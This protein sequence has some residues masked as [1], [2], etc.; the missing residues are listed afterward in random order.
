MVDLLH[1][2]VSGN[3]RT[4]RILIEYDGFMNS[5]SERLVLLMGLE[6]SNKEKYPKLKEILDL[7]GDDIFNLANLYTQDDLNRFIF[8]GDL[9]DDYIKELL[10]ID[11]INFQRKSIFGYSFFNLLQENY[12]ENI[13]II[14]KDDYLQYELESLA[15][16]FGDSFDKVS[17][18]VGET[19][20]IVED[21][22]FTT[23]CLND[24]DELFKIINTLDLEYVQNT[25]FILRNTSR[26]ILINPEGDVHLQFTQEIDDIM[27][28]KEVFISRVFSQCIDEDSLEV[29]NEDECVG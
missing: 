18:Y 6:E 20:S 19:Y 27:R 21:S 13:S 3:N 12:V 2:V 8:N 24:I 7:S 17:L 5:I 23:I 14:K 9:S 15:N 26:N 29:I 25:F 22:K 4:E 16:A 28:E 10:N 1:P 11:I